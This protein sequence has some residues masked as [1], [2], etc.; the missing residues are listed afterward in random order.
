MTLSHTHDVGRPN[1]GTCPACG[2]SSAKLSHDTRCQGGC[3]KVRSILHADS[4]ADWLCNDCRTKHTHYIAMSGSHGCLPDSCNAYEQYDSAVAELAS[5]FELGRTRKARLFADGTLELE[6]E[7]DG[8]EYCEIVSCQCAKPW[9]HCD[10]GDDPRDW[11]DYPRPDSG[12]EMLYCPTCKR[13]F[14]H[15][16]TDPATGSVGSI[17]CPLCGAAEPEDG[18]QQVK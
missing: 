18:F 7:N 5:M 10:A 13:E 1:D 2:Y 12:T 6:P 16:T 15:D 4:P 3:G 14:D 17:Q 11:E 9:E 8:A